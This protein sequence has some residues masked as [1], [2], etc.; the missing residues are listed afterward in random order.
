[1]AAR[2]EYSSLVEPYGCTPNLMR[3]P[4]GS[5][6]KALSVLVVAHVCQR[7]EATHSVPYRGARFVKNSDPRISPPRASDSA[8]PD[9]ELSARIRP[10]R[11]PRRLCGRLFLL[12][13]ARRWMRRFLGAA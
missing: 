4:S 1:M 10:S 12:G 11:P 5:T 6:R 3:R 8:P 13:V 9:R 2:P 7:T